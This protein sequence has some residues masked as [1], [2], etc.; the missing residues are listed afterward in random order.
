MLSVPLITR[1]Q[2]TGVLSFRWRTK[3]LGAEAESLR[4]FATKL[5]SSVSLALANA[6]LFENEHRV[7]ET[8]QS[9]IT[10][11]PESMSGVTVGSVYRPA[12]G[13]GRI[14]GDFYDVF[15]LSDGRV[16]FLL[17]DV[18][19]KGL[20]AAAIT[21]LARS[22]IRALAYRTPEPATV[23]AA[24]NDAL[25]RQLTDS[26]FVTVAY[27]VLDPVTL[28]VSIGLAGHPEPIVAGRPDIVPADHQRNPPLGVPSDAQFA[29]WSFVLLSNDTLVLYSDGI[30][31][32]RSGGKLFGIDRIRALLAPCA[33]AD[34]QEAAD[35]LMAAAATFCDGSF[36]DDVAI[37]ALRPSGR[38]N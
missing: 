32:A 1:G 6:R 21:A 27:G 24:A 19:G 4:R 20:E 9:A 15:A 36:R 29:E 7:A 16:A 25:M 14:G 38:P 18:S 31:E 8:L 10:A 30:C 12:P 23:L 37:L 35:T 26:D 2:P 11:P 5:S 22:T 28:A 34:P 13:I 33:G 3:S 17:G